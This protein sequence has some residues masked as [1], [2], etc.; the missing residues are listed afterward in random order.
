MVDIE[1]L[2]AGPRAAV[3]AIGAVVFSLDKELGNTYEQLINPEFAMEA[4]E[5]SPDTME[6]WQRQD[7]DVRRRMFSG[8]M[9]P[10]EAAGKFAAWVRE[11]R[12][13]EVWANSPSF[14][15]IILRHLF[16]QTNVTCPWG[17]RDE[18]CVRTVF[19]EAKE[20]GF[21]YSKAYAGASA[22]DAL[23]DAKAQAMAVILCKRGGQPGLL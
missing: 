1:T 18:R 15:C 3:I 12:V 20:R 17:F 16:A 23:S 14:D 21:D 4:G 9:G 19:A 22:H 11:Q 13:R 8:T 5:S 10:N 6:W 2:S 7:I